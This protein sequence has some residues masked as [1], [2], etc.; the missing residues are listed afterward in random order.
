MIQ[1]DECD[2][3][4][5]CPCV[6]YFKESDC[7][8]H[9]VCSPCRQKKGMRGLSGPFALSLPPTPPPSSSRRPQGRTQPTLTRRTIDSNEHTSTPRSFRDYTPPPSSSTPTRKIRSIIETPDSVLGDASPY[10]AVPASS[11]GICSPANGKIDVEEGGQDNSDDDDGLEVLPSS[12]ASGLCSSPSSFKRTPTHLSKLPISPSSNSSPR[13]A[14]TPASNLY[15]ISR[16]LLSQIQMDNG[17]SHSSSSSPS[18]IRPTSSH[19]LLSPSK[20]RKRETALDEEGD[21]DVIAPDSEPQDDLDPATVPLPEHYTSLLNLHSSVERALLLH[22]ATEGSRAASVTSAASSS[23][24]TVEGGL[25]AKLAASQNDT[26]HARASE[27]DLMVDL[28]NLVSY[29]TIRGT[30]ERGSKK[31]FGLN[32]LGQLIW[33]W[34]GGLDGPNALEHEGGMMGDGATNASSVIATASCS[35]SRKRRGGLSISVSSIRE[36]DKRKMGNA[37][38][39]RVVYNWGIGINLTIKQN[40]QLPAFEIV[41]D[42]PAISRRSAGSP[43]RARVGGHTQGQLSFTGSPGSSGS[44][45]SSS[46][47]TNVSALKRTGMSVLPLWSSK[48][49]YRKHEMRSRLGRCVIKAYQDFQARSEDAAAAATR[50]ADLAARKRSAVDGGGGGA[51]ALSSSSSAAAAFAA[52][53]PTPPPSTRKQPKY[54]G[55]F[56]KGFILD[57]LPPIPSATLPTLGPATTHTH[58]HAHAN[59]LPDG[60]THSVN[61]VRGRAAVAGTRKVA[62]VDADVARMDTDKQT[63]T[64]TRGPGGVKTTPQHPLIDEEEKRKLLLDEGRNGSSSGL[65]PPRT[66]KAP[67]NQRAMSLL[68]RVSLEA[69]GVS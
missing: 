57:A 31:K 50:S 40:K 29:S 43:T 5:H 48:S 56:A 36:M 27:G 6:G 41:D 38:G 17:S 19:P 61:G 20:K 8:E 55:I 37:N 1:C 34:E 64:L 7:P 35:S 54:S 63:N 68:E 16:N 44:G 67:A 52:L 12:P 18:F 28:P 13:S 58:P 62:R 4:Q 23:S 49:E 15:N 46:G 47:S 59:G 32:E 60:T 11:D 22:L 66:P 2:A 3:W 42:S 51:A 25:S 26:S 33:L 45:S 21:M 39:K 69:R 53:L 14:S 65:L 24:T 9:Y 10:T 30:V